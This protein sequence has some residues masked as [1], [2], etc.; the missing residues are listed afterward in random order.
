MDL[1]NGSF[2]L[3]GALFLSKNVQVLYRDKIVRGVHWAPT[4]FFM[5][6][7]LWNMAYYPNLGQWWSFL[8]GLAV[9]TVNAL[10]LGM[11][12]YYIQR[13]KNA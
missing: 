6:W 4:S 11:M 1:L 12:V 2:E 9:V 3:A 10:W 7:G 5:V 13:E 8:G